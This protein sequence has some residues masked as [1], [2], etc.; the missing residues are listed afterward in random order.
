MKTL[1]FNRELKNFYILL[2][3]EFISEFG[4]KMTSFALIMWEFEKSG[5]VM[6]AS[7]LTIC[8]LLP[9]ILLSFF[10]GSL[11][12]SWN[13]KRI[14]I[15]GTGKGAGNGLIYIIIALLGFA[16]CCFFKS[17]KHLKSLD[18]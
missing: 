1:K 17:N 11:I 16:G 7:K 15:V 5:S 10:A 6:S 2:L 18:D 14:I 12:D 4:S 9:S 3:G 8:T 13:K